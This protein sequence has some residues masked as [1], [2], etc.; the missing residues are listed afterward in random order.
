MYEYLPLTIYSIIYSSTPLTNR[1]F[2]NWIQLKHKSN[3]WRSSVKCSHDIVPLKGLHRL[4]QLLFGDYIVMTKQSNDNTFFKTYPFYIKLLVSQNNWYKNMFTL[5]IAC[6]IITF[7]H[8]MFFHMSLL[9]L[10]IFIFFL[11]MYLHVND[12]RYHLY[13]RSRAYTIKLY[14]YKN[15]Y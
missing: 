4:D 12:L 11:P 9:L 15:Y 1:I 5:T 3:K 8:V 7:F 2:L 13:I 10:L 6:C 14:I